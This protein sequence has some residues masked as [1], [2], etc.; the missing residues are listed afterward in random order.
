V[1]TVTQMQILAAAG[2]S[3]Y[4]GYLFSRPM[5]EEAVGSYL[6]GQAGRARRPQAV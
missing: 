6:A 2:V 5:P 3:G 4:Q 1:E